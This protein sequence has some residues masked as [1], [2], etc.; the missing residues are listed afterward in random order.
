MISGD[1]PVREDNTTTA[2]GRIEDETASLGASRARPSEPS[3]GA[4]DDLANTC[5][6]V[7]H[8]LGRSSESPEAKG[9]G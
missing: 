9:V 7:V 5:A 1:E 8:E 2:R 6:G 3:T 4:H